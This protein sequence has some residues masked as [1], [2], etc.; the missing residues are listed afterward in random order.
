MIQTEHHEWPQ[1]R[2][3]R[4]SSPEQGRHDLES[5]LAAGE[6]SPCSLGWS[7]ERV[8]ICAWCSFV[9]EEEDMLIVIELNLFGGS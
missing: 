9:A 5:M 6:L 2:S 3:V 7:L 8:D 4:S 1:G